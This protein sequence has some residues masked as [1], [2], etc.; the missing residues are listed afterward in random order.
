ML[1]VLPGLEM[2]KPQHSWCANQVL[3][4]PQPLRENGCLWYPN[5]SFHIQVSA[6]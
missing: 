4:G 6:K 1:S 2:R 5:L 3:W